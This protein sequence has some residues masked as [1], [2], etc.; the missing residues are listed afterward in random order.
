[1]ASKNNKLPLLFLIKI[2]ANFPSNGP[3]INFS[4]GN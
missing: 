3:K 1:M 4:K 2:T